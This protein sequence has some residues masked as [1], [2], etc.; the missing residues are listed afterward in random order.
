MLASTEVSLDDLIASMESYE[1][2][3][4]YIGTT[5]EVNHDDAEMVSREVK[6]FECGQNGHIAIHFSKRKGR[7]GYG[8][9]GKEKSNVAQDDFAGGVVENDGGDD[10]DFSY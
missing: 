9:K 1:L 6:C 5:E 2:N 10:S 7:K 4:G 3:W 8:G